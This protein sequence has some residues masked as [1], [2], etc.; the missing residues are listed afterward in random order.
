MHNLQLYLYLFVFFSIIGWGIEF[1][2]RSIRSRTLINPGFLRGPY[3]PVYGT[4][5]V[6]LTLMI[7]FFREH[8]LI[9]ILPFSNLPLQLID[10]PEDNVLKAIALISKGTLY[11]LLTTGIEL[12]TGLVFIRFLKKRLWNYEHRFLSIADCVCL[13]YSIYWVI[14]A[15]S[16]EYLLLPSTL[17]FIQSVHP[18]L[19]HVITTA[20]LL[21]MTID[22]FKQF[23][24]RSGFQYFRASADTEPDR[25]EFNR[26]IQPLLQLPQ[27]QHLAGYRHHRN[28]TRLA[29]SLEVAWY[30]YTLS[31][32]WSRDY[33]AA[34]RG[35]L[36]HD[37]FFYNW[38]SEGPRLHGFRHPK[39]ALKNAEAIVFLNPV[40]RDIIKKHMW[41]LT[42]VPPRYLESWAVCIADTYCSFRDY[43]SPAEKFKK[44]YQKKKAIVTNY[45]KKVF[46]H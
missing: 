10:I 26:I 44:D 8:H 28:K 1:L 20:V 38:L 3:L 9:F 4:A 41:P 17:K 15:F 32:K 33:I 21:S 43:L 14:L 30:G 24:L 23:S 19:L 37:L 31:K 6:L 29:H 22:F 36:L 13:K 45:I 35:G 46:L 34:A 7:S 11:A 25:D 5:V 2:Y 16:Y 42:P 27:V 12:V 18:I 39:I 40:E